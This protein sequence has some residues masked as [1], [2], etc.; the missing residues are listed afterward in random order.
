[1]LTSS[2]SKRAQLHRQYSSILDGSVLEPGISSVLRI[3]DY[4][5][6]HADINPIFQKNTQEH[7]RCY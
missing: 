1:M 2:D 4:W 3:P 5:S 7:S 6:L